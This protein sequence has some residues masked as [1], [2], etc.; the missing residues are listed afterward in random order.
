[1]NSSDWLALFSNKFALLSFLSKNYNYKRESTDRKRKFYFPDDRRLFRIRTPISCIS[2]WTCVNDIHSY[3]FVFYNCSSS[4]IAAAISLV[5]YHWRYSNLAFRWKNVASEASSMRINR[6]RFVPFTLL[7]LSCLSQFCDLLL[8]SQHFC[9]WTHQLT[10]K[11]SQ[12]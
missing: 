6:N 12:R 1:M 11:E 10:I 8:F 4:A 3:R 5:F 7:T 9:Y 2:F